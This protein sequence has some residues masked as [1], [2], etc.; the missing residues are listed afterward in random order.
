MAHC[1]GNRKKIDSGRAKVS[2]APKGRERF[3]P[4]LS[5]GSAR[6]TAGPFSTRPSGTKG[7]RQATILKT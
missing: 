1:Q 4:Q 2:S 3:S 5:Q 6:S 7:S